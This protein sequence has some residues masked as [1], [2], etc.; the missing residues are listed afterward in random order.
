M[1]GVHLEEVVIMGLASFRLTRLVVYDKICE[2]IRRPFFDELSE[3]NESGET[4]VYY[5][6]KPKGIKNIIGELLS[7]YW[8]FGIWATLFLLLLYW[9]APAA[10]NIF[11]IL[12]AAAAVGSIIETAISRVFDS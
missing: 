6:P 10:G 1:L 11:I 7:C 3:I 4:E 2:F 5:I 12:L 9:L 8:C